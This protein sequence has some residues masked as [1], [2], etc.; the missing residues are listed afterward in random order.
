MHGGVTG[1]GVVTSALFRI[2]V[3]GGEGGD[4]DVG[5]LTLEPMRSAGRR[6]AVKEEPWALGEVPPEP[7]TEIDL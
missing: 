3:N 6:T 5:A 1:A 2:V 4:V 7:V